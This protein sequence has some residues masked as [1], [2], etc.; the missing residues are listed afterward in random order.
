MHCIALMRGLNVGRANR[1]TMKALAAVFE[2]AGAEDV[3]TYI[4]S[5]NVLFTASAAVLKT[6]HAKV[7]QGLEKHHVRSPVVLRTHAELAKVPGRNPFL[8]RQVPLE[9]LHVGFLEGTPKK[10]P[11]PPS[12]SPHDVFEL[13]GREVYLWY[14]HG[15]GRSKLTTAWLDKALGTRITVRNWKTVTTLVARSEE[16]T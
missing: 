8:A 6:L 3:T 1:I 11:L 14:P 12:P 5:G 13:D 2:A 16:R 7:E 9:Q 4:Q 10:G 15:L